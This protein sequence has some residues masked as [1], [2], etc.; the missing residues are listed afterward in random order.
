MG[1]RLKHRSAG[2]EHIMSA[3]GNWCCKERESD[4]W[5]ILRDAGSIP[6]NIELENLVFHELK[7]KKKGF[8][9]RLFPNPIAAV[10]FG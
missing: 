1:C 10:G 7:L 4:N 3:T 9:K 2:R 5:L 8:W 6:A